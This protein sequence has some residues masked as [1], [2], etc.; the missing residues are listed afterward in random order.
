MKFV[1]IMNETLNANNGELSRGLK[2][3]VTIVP[4][5]TNDD[6]NEKINLLKE[7]EINVY[8]YIGIRALEFSYN[9][10]QKTLQNNSEKLDIYRSN[11]QEFV[12]DLRKEEINDFGSN[13][14]IDN[15]GGMSL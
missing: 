14:E 10:I 4:A 7:S 15:M 1:Q 11:L 6:L 3:Q 2:N 9:I 5:I 13:L 8:N 12:R